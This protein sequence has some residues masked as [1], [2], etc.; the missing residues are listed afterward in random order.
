MPSVDRPTL[1][2]DD[3]NRHRL[4]ATWSRSSRLV[5]S[6]TDNRFA[7][8]RQIQLRPDQVAELIAYLEASTTD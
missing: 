4:H 2:L 5:L 6:V 1:T 3:E 8:V 7:E